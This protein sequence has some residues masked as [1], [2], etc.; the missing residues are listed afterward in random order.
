MFGLKQKPIEIAPLAN[1]QLPPRAI[2]ELWFATLRKG[3]STL[4]VVPADRGTS[5]EPIARALGE[6]GG[7][8]RGRPLS[9]MSTNGLD[10]AAVGN[11]VADLRPGTPAAGGERMILAIEPIADNPMGIAAALAADAVLLC[12]ELGR[13]T[14]EGARHTIEQ[15]GAD[16]FI[17]CVIL[18]RP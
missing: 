14:L 7:R 13:T 4:A 3:W 2:Q 11:I 9:V 18:Q 17:G 15:I 5:A 10:L 16:R 12:V 1:G 6:F 8:H